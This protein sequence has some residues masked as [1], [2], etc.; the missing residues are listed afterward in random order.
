MFSIT[1]KGKPSPKDK[2]WIKIE[3]ILFQTGYTRV[4]KVLNITGLY[5]DWIPHNQCFSENSSDNI[6]RNQTLLDIKKKYMEVAEKWEREEK[7]WSPIQWSHSFDST[8]NQ[9][10]KKESIPKVKVL[11][12]SRCFDIIIE[13]MGNR[14]RIRNGKVFTSSATARNYKYC[15]YTLRDF[16]QEVYGR[17]F[18]SY[19]FRDIDE[20][21]MKDYV[22]YL[23]QR[24]LKKGNKGGVCERLRQFYG[25][26]YYS[27]KMGV[28]D[29][30]ETIFKPYRHLTKRFKK[31]KTKTVPFNIIEKIENMDKSNFSNKEKFWLDVFLFSFYAGGMAN[32][33][34]CYLTWDSIVDNELNFERIKFHKKVKMPL[35]E[36]AKAIIDKYKDQCFGNYVLPIFTH[37]H[38]TEHKQ[39]DCVKRI[40]EKLNRTLKKA[41]EILK[42][43][44]KL[45]W[46]S[47]RGTF[48]TKMLDEGFHPVEVA[49]FAGNSPKTIYNNYWKQTKTEEISDRINNVL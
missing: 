35:S 20:Q 21:F 13:E 8:E 47:C 7:P 11:T 38:D 42:I 45:T 3:M 4:S 10:N 23:Q 2:N 25:V 6:Q 46:N 18:S 22:L 34:V 36:K 48:I 1:F 30:D 19:Y 24:G 27:D 33:D 16:T 5:K 31:T 40:R 43:E 32:I 14:K 15:R 17:N 28:T 49:E 37:K 39:R 12:V 26:F 29:V 9:E 44:E 41:T